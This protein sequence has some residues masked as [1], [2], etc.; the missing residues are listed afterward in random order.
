MSSCCKEESCRVGG[1]V[2]GKGGEEG[3]EEGRGGGESRKGERERRG[4]GADEREGGADEREG[5]VG[6]KRE[7][8]W[9]GKRKGEGGKGRK[10]VDG[11]KMIT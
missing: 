4:G 10:Y 8:V 3:R 11:S 1:R 9:E 2:G 7:G 5:R 6:L